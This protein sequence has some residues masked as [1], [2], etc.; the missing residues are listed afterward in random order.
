M[1]NNVPKYFVPNICATIPFVGGIV[2]N[3]KIPNKTPKAS[4]VNVDEGKNRNKINIMVV[5]TE[6]ILNL[7]ILVLLSKFQF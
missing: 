1:P 4:A 7:L 6:F 2:A 5:F 3:H